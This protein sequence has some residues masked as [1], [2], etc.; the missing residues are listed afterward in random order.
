MPNVKP[1]DPI[2]IHGVSPRSGTNYL[3]D[4]LLLHPDCGAGRHPVRED[5][6]LDNANLLTTFTTATREA[7]DPRWGY[8]EDDIEAELRAS[9]GD[10]LISFLW[11][12]KEKRLVTK[13]PSVRNLGLFFDFFPRARLVI[14]MRDGR[15]VVESCM[16]TFGWDFDTATRKWSAAAEE[17]RAFMTTAA[18]SGLSYR[19]VAYEEL[20]DDVEHSLGRLFDDLQLD[21]EL[22]DFAAARTLP[23]R[24]SSAFFGAG[25]STVHWDPVP[26]DEDFDPRERWRQWSSPQH[27]RFNWVAEDLL[28][29]FGYEPAGASP[30]NAASTLRHSLLDGRWRMAKGFSY[31]LFRARVRVG[32]ATRPLRRRLGLLRDP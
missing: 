6:F 9:I 20:V 1:G 18:S 27:E 3:W 31:L 25:K 8:F 5:L 21:K 7:W 12:D 23:V 17:I 16:R 13:N 10:G 4:L 26:R 19:L 22:Y 32:T 11:T 2:F 29:Y 30:A 24:G 28:R 15:S 14:L